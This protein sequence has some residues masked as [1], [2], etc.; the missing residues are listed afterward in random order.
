[1]D[2]LAA[3]DESGTSRGVLETAGTLARLLAADVEA[4]YVHDDDPSSASE[5]IETIAV[6]RRV[7]IGDPATAI[8]TALGD[9][10]VAMAVIGTGRGRNGTHRLGHVAQDVMTGASKPVVVVPPEHLS[11]GRAAVVTGILSSARVPV[12]LV[13]VAQAPALPGALPPTPVSRPLGA[14]R[15]RASRRNNGSLVPS[16]T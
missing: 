15:V 8:L 11:V 7:L 16:L 10:D 9:D 12:L 3:V 14:A 4:V 2:I 1:M 5:L 6:P 13:P